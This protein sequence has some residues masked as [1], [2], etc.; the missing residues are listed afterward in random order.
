MKRKVRR[1]HW[2]K[3][4]NMKTNNTE[5]MKDQTDF[6]FYLRGALDTCY[7]AVGVCVRECARAL[8]TQV[9]RVTNS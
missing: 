9:L 6:I 5:V 4:E 7:R 1:I 8:N 3:A 2:Y